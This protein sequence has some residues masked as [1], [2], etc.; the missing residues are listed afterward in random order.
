MFYCRH[1]TVNIFIGYGRSSL[2]DVELFVTSHRR[3]GS[4]FS[5]PALQDAI[6]T[7]LEPILERNL[8]GSSPPVRVRIVA[9]RK[10]SEVDK[11]Q[12]GKLKSKI[13]NKIQQRRRRGSAGGS[14]GAASSRE[15]D[16]FEIRL[17]E[18]VARDGIMHHKFI[19]IDDEILITGSYNWTKGAAE[20]N[21]E[22]II[23]LKHPDI[24]SA[25]A[26]EFEALWQEFPPT[27]PGGGGAGSRRG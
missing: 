3:P 22:N 4:V 13:Q 1:S 8:L 16:N 6:A 9:D 18:R 23:I 24:T 21:M 12:L 26:D 15:T 5:H 11:S 2:Q 14:S 7:A 20:R 25:Y 19:V 27:P 10:M 17:S